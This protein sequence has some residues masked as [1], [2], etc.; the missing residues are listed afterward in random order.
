M[1]DDFHNYLPTVMFRG[2]GCLYKCVEKLSL[3]IGC[4][5]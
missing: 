1:E 3:I 4:N 2:T 5:I